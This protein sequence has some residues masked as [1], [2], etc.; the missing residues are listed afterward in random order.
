LNPEYFE[1]LTYKN[2][3]LRQEALYEKDPA[4]QKQ[5]LA[6]ADTIRNKALDVQKKQS[7][8]AATPNKD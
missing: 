1:A 2:I 3:L 7:T 4:K 8:Q 6:E 5:L